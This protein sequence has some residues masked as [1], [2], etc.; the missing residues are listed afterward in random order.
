MKLRAAS[1]STKE[2]VILKQSLFGFGMAAVASFAAE[3][4]VAGTAT[5]TLSVSM[6]IQAS[7]TLSSSSAVAFGTSGVL[8]SNVDATGSLSV[9]CTN[10]TPYTVAL[11]QGA[12]SGATTST[13]KM[14][15]SGATVSYNLYRDSARTQNWGNATGTDTV[16]GTGNGAAQTLTVYG[17]VPAQSTPAPGS[18]SD[19]VNVTITY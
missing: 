2:L 14:T 7:C 13:R 19:T 6:T 18:Y 10:T 4:A 11:D 3:P 1:F 8:A 5:G 17:R 12:G 16:A 15:G 9:Q